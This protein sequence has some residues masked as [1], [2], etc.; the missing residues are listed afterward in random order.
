MAWMKK[1]AIHRKFRTQADDTKQCLAAF[2]SANLRLPGTKIT[3]AKLPPPETHR[4][5]A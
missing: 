2:L 4:F 1:T 5:S 3:I